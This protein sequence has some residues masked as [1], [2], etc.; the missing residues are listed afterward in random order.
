MDQGT[1]FIFWSISEQKPEPFCLQLLKV[2]ILFYGYP[3][4]LHGQF[5]QNLK[6]SAEKKAW[7]ISC[8]ATRHRVTSRYGWTTPY[9]VYSLDVFNLD[10][11][12]SLHSQ[13][14]LQSQG[15]LCLCWHTRLSVGLRAL[16]RTS[17]L[18]MVSTVPRSQI[19]SQLEKKLRE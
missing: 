18:R 4:F 13:R 14:C 12:F 6:L 5:L 3:H 8:T 19:K 7:R 16:G 9:M 15:L 10:I 17:R 11:F 2:F 1:V